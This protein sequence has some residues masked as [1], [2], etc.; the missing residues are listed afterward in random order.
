VLARRPPPPRRGARVDELWVAAGLGLL[1]LVRDH[2][3]RTTP[4]G[5]PEIDHAF[6]QACHGGQLRVAAYLLEQGADINATPD[7]SDAR[8]LEI[9][10]APDTRR[11]LL[12]EWLAT[13]AAP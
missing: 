6:W 11:G 1:P 13:R 4:P 12:V 5:R 10:G 2:F 9:A 7:H 8:P 3:E